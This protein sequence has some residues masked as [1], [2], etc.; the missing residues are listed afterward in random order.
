MKGGPK[1]SHLALESLHFVFEL[2]HLFQAV[3]SFAERRGNGVRHNAG[4]VF[5]S[6]PD[7]LLRCQRRDCRVK[8]RF[9]DQGAKLLFSGQT[10]DDLVEMFF[11]KLQESEN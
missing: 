9:C 11:G 2:Q 4:Q 6:L 8:V 1:F 7:V 10:R 3:E 5:H